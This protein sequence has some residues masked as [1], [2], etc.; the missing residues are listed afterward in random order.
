[1]KQEKE[2]YDILIEIG[3]ELFRQKGYSNT[4][5]Q[6]II[7]KAK[8]SKGGFYH[9]FKNKEDFAV[10][11]L[12]VH[13]NN[14]IQ[15]LEK[16]V[17]EHQGTPVGKIK[18]TLLARINHFD[19]MNYKRGSL[20]MQLLTEASANKSPLLKTVNRCYDQLYDCIASQLSEAERI[21]ELKNTGNYTTKELAI[22]IYSGF[23][24]ALVKARAE[25]SR[26]TLDIYTRFL[27]AFLDQLKS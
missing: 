13:T 5:V 22:F 25:R 23:E 4:G 7:D 12:N 3:S 26:Y 20:L 18:W 24:G 8:T 19:Q 27:F 11:I 21:G 2:V 6:E 15:G 17:N 16:L 14:I 10:Q 1:M 9:H